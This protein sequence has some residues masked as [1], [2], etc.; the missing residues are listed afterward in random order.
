MHNHHNREIS[1]EK[2]KLIEKIKE[3]RDIHI[4]EYDEAVIAYKKEAEVQLKRIT[5]ELKDGNLKLKLDLVTPVNRSAD[6]NKVI[7]MFEWEIADIVKLTQKE[8]NEYIHDETSD[9]IYTRSLNNTYL[10]KF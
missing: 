3:N 2:N 6:Y 1:I 7:E 8:F 10:N 5:K 9:A 4:K